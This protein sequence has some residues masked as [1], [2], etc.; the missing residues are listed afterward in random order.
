MVFLNHLFVAFLILGSG[1]FL[2]VFSP[3]NLIGGDISFLVGTIGAQIWL[4]VWAIKLRARGVARFDMLVA[5]ELIIA[6]GVLSLI[7]GIFISIAFAFGTSNQSADL[8]IENLRP[9][10]MPFAGGLFAA[11][12][13]PVLATVLRQLEVLKYGGGKDSGGG[14]VEDD[15]DHVK[16]KFREVTSVLNTFITACERSQA[17]FEKS[18]TSFNKSADAYERGAEK[19]LV[20]L[21]R[22]GNAATSESDRLTKGLVSIADE[23]GKYQEKLAHS[24]REMAS[25][26]VEVRGFHEATH[27]GTTLLNGLN[28]LIESVE[29]FI[30]PGS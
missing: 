3:T 4:F 15:L 25:L 21:D 22:L 6:F 28:R 10:L 30:R 2:K 5:S 26:T 18:A 13:A 20:A 24:S 9:L 7:L 23:L 12:I 17:T 29:R 11:G 16:E 1:I 19:A 8:T 27:E 14:T